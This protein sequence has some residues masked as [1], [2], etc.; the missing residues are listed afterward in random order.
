MQA[1][2]TWIF[3]TVQNDVLPI[4]SQKGNVLM[5]WSLSKILRVIKYNTYLLTIVY[6]FDTNT[7]LLVDSTLNTL[8][9]SGT[10]LTPNIPLLNEQ[11]NTE[12]NSPSCNGWVI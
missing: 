10:Y 2:Q 5:I 8:Q 6:L 3:D 12:F 7:S 11:F 1:F 4:I 9:S